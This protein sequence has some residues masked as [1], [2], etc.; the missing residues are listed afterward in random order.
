M[1]KGVRLKFAEDA[2]R[3]HAIAVGLL[4]SLTAPALLAD[5]DLARRKLAD[6]LHT[7]WETGDSVHAATDAKFK[8]V[9]KAGAGARAYYGQALVLMYQRR[10]EE[11]A[12]ALEQVVKVD[13]QHLAGWRAKIWLALLTKKYGI[14]LAGMEHLATAAGKLAEDAGNKE[15]AEEAVRFLGSVYGFVD[16]PLGES[17]AGASRKTTEKAILAAL[18]EEQQVVFT[19]ARQAVMEK[20]AELTNERQGSR[21]SAIADEEAEKQKVLAD[22]EK[23]RS[24]IATQGEELKER[25]AKVEGELKDELTEIGRLD[26]PLLTQLTSLQ[27]QAAAV[28][29]NA[30]TVALDIQALEDQFAREKDQNIRDQIRRDINRLR[31]LLG[32]YDGELA[33]I[34]TAIAGV[35]GQR[36]TLATRQ[37]KAQ[38]TFGSQLQSIDRQFAA[39]QAEE[40]KLAGAERKANKPSTGS[41]GKVSALNITATALKT[42]EPFP[43]EQERERLLESLK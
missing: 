21:E 23:R 40:R 19:E 30:D 17:A 15:A 3:V 13:D 12:K 39:F 43:I 25:R 35:Q 33:V 6:F 31:P 36:A 26:R 18:S 27:A 5:D 20:F 16:G 10:Y 42:Y 24:E 32:R 37:A 2:M 11:A 28:R 14:G 22:V 29:R 41:T 9:E 8:A 7:C 34:S 38:N 4:F 1:L